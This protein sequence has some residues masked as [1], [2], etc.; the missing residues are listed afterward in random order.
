[1]KALGSGTYYRRCIIFKVPP[2][3]ITA[4][5]FAKLVSPFLLYIV[6]AT[7]LN[8]FLIQV[9]IHGSMVHSLNDAEEYIRKNSINDNAVLPTKATAMPEKAPVYGDLI[10]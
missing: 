6:S 10:K 1:M 7:D 9:A 8:V 5:Y 3:T 4:D 2:T